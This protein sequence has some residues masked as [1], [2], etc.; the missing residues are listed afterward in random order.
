MTLMA[1]P[2]R[3]PSAG[4]ATRRRGAVYVVVLGVSMIVAI[5][6]VSALMLTRVE[7]RAAVADEQAVS[8]R[9]AALSGLELGL[10]WLRDDPD[11]RTTYT[12][13][14]WTSPMAIEGVTYRFKAVDEGDGDLADDVDDPVRLYCRADV[15][16]A[17]RIF[18]TEF[19]PDT[20][21]GATGNL[22][23]NPDFEDGT[24][25]WT[26]LGGCQ[27][28][29]DAA[30]PHGGDRSLWV[31][32]RGG[33]WDGPRQEDL[34]ERLENGVT[35]DTECWVRLKNYSEPVHLRLY[36]GTAYGWFYAPISTVNAGTSWTK[37]SGSVNLSL[38]FDIHE[39]YWK[40]E[41]AWSNQEFWVDDA[42]LVE[43]DTLII[44]P[45]LPVPGTC[46]REILATPAPADVAETPKP[47]GGLSPTPVSK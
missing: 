33:S 41:T 4:P 27:V 32:N 11:W 5:I 1:R 21:A 45:L 20:S 9:F 14:A 13:D 42:V 35:Y 18:S 34:A 36:L 43:H 26:G 40:V 46:R 3:L 7:L 16:Q 10:L 44:I 15:E 8:A 24:D 31:R 12:H 28:L 30:Q 6:G 23:L 2:H 38:P 37:L 19:R 39:A 22:L 29:L 47:V 17:V 25:P